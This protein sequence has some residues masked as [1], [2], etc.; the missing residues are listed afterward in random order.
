MNVR[1]VPKNTVADA[2]LK[3]IPAPLFWASLMYFVFRALTIVP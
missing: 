2:A 1:P 3:P